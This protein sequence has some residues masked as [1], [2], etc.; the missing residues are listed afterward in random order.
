VGNAHNARPDA[1]RKTESESYG[2]V[3]FYRKGEL[4]RANVAI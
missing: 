4:E 2:L 1:I 3:Y